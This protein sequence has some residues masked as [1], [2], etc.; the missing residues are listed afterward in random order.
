[1]GVLQGL[2]FEPFLFL[3]YIDDLPHLVKNG[4]GMVLF[5]DDT[6]LLFKIDRHQPAFDE[7]RYIRAVYDLR[8]MTSHREKIKVIDILT[9]ASQY[10]YENLVYV[11]RHI[12]SFQK[13]NDIHNI[14]TRHKNDLAAHKN[15]LSSRSLPVPSLDVTDLLPPAF[16]AWK[17]AQL[18][19][20]ER[21]ITSRR[22]V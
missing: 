22:R 7:E 16:P 1:M 17:E 20:S 19:A 15:R 5:A 2:V 9:L 3:V 4:H 10:I 12:E 21:G 14:N 11:K 6:F 18:S 13:R 8:S